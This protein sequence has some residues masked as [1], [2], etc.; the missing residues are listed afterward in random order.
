MLLRLLVFV[1]VVVQFRQAYLKKHLR[2][3]DETL[4]Y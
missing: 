1:V 2:Y 3:G 4:H